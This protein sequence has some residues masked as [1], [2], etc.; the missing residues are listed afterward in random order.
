M[1]KPQRHKR[2]YYTS[3]EEGEEEEEAY[4]DE[5][6]EDVDYSYDSYP[7]SEAEEYACSSYHAPIGKRIYLDFFLCFFA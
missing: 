7:A 3:D 6:I 1:I 4:T 5:Y 2:A